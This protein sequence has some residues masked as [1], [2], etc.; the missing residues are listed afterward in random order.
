LL[1]GRIDTPSTDVVTIADD[2][3]K[4]TETVEGLLEPGGSVA[5]TIGLAR[6]G[7]GVPGTA[8][9]QLS[10]TL[11]TE[12]SLT[13][14][15]ASS[16]TV[17]TEGNT[18][19][20]AGSVPALGS[21]EVTIQGTIAGGS[22]GVQISNQG[23]VLFDGN[24][25]GVMEAQ[26]LT[27]DPSRPGLA[28]PTVFQVGT[29][30]ASYYTLTPCRLVDTRNATGELG[31]PSLTGQGDRTFTLSGAC[32][33]P[34]TAKALAV[35]VTV[36]GAT[37]AGNLRIHPPGLIGPTSTINYVEAQTR[38]NNAVIAL[39]AQGRVGV[40]CGQAAGTSVDFILDVDGYFE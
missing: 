4:A 1:G 20:W 3:V 6:P 25:D 39:D 36:T 17:S 12:L 13:L 5:Y 23:S 27:D 31:G 8:Q 2:D 15:S 30:P 19:A 9:T 21:V 26:G 11:A 16:G 28:D 24:G 37:A 33:I 32:A 40:F 22:A 14:A 7:T 10:D 34:T 18:V 35:N 29:G 38:A